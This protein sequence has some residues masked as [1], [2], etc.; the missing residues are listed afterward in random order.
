MR[1]LRLPRASLRQ[2][3]LKEGLEGAPWRRAR[4][5]TSR[6]EEAGREEL[7]EGG[8]EE[9]VKERRER[10]RA[11]HT[12]FRRK[13]MEEGKRRKGGE[14]WREVRRLRGKWRKESWYFGQ[15]GIKE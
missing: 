5:T 7:E 11:R 9:R 13:K 14:K 6:R 3:S 10:W 8:R 4:H 2:K 12:G 15:G 1:S